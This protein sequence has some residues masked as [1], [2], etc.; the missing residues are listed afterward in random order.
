MIA[1]KVLFFYG[2]WWDYNYAT[3]H[4]VVWAPTDAKTLFAPYHLLDRLVDELDSTCN[5]EEF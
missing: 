4:F 1:K 2:K 5:G 3:H